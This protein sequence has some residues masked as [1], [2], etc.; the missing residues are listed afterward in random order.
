MTLIQ[1]FHGTASNGTPLT[2]VYAEQPAAAAAFALVFPGSDLPRF[3]HWG[4]PL[5]APETVINTFD[6][7][8]PQRVSGALDY[9][10]WPSV[11]PTQSE[12]WSGSDRFDVR[13]DGVELFCKFQVT[14]IKAETVAAGK[15]YTMAE[16]DGYPSWSVASEP[17]Q[18]PTVTVTAEDV[19]QCVK[20]TWTCEL[21][22]TGLIRQ[23][24]EVTN[25]G[26]GRLEIG[27][28]ELAFSVPADANEI[29]TTTGH[30]LRERSPQRQ[31][32]TIGR[33]AKSSMIGRPDFDATLLLSVGEHGFGFTHGN[34]YSAHVAWSGNSVLSA[35]RLPYTTGVIGGG[36]LLFGGEVTLAGPGEGQNS[37]D[38]PWLFGSYGDGLNE[39]A[40][41]FHSY[42]RSLHPR[43][44]SHGRPV[45]L[46]TWEAVYFDHNFDTLKALADKAADSGV[47]RFVVDDGWFGSRRDDTSGLG[48]WQIAQDVWPDGPKS[49]KAL[50]DYV[51]AKGM[52]FGLWF[53]PEMVN[54]DSD[55][56]RNHPDWILSPTAGRLPL[57]G[58]TQQV[59]D[60]TNPDAFDY[61]YGCM[62]QLV[63]ELGIDY[64]KWD[65]NKL[66][67]EPGS[68]RS[69]RPA[70]HAQ[71]LA[72]YN[73]FKGLKTAHPGL[74]IE[75]CS[76]GGGRVD[77]GILEHADRIWVSDCVDPV[78][79]ADIQRYT[80][81][82]VP[83]AMMGEHV[84]ASPAHSTQ[85][86]TSQELR[87]AMAFF[88]HMGI[89]WNLLKEPDEALAKLA[90]W[91]AEFKKHRDWF[92]I[93]TCVHA[94]SNDPAVRLDGMVMP[95]RDAA[96]YRF[97][98]LTTSQTYPAAPVHLPGL[99]PERTYRVSPLDPS[100]DL[101]GLTNGQSTL[102]WWNE[103]GVVLTGEA[104]QRYGIRPPSLHPQQA[105]LLKAVALS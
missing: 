7:L 43:L 41:R 10:A 96:I 19:E 89:E 48:D 61:I 18:T 64:I 47:E 105:V 29:L 36:E 65:H 78:E 28:I 16:K 87:M 99:D 49:L 93:D 100:L 79:R 90:V 92:A 5:T 69:G 14:D 80:S 26:E 17:K 94:D 9:T 13:R 40:A 59:L 11:L 37:Y 73:I 55:V 85:R 51:H 3:V 102:G 38:T 60:L 86:A 27:K 21:D 1:T 15:T 24:A 57:Q 8:A 45:I 46:N 53:E 58:R 83:P 32:F 35:D 98:Q 70:V 20:L 12:A 2:A 95:N 72:V 54:P 30:H 66:V 52:E 101:T 23:H 77:L 42:V 25:T 50:A 74:E 56:A 75:S 71:T 104:L 6:A 68:R 62:D 22:E 34:V 39:I 81:L 44:F 4:R 67:T 31:D 91:V 76:S 82:L 88:G 103:E 33:F 97:T 84:G 63:G